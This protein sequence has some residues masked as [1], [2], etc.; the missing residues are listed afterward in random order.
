MFYDSRLL[1]IYSNYGKH[2]VHLFAPGHA[3]FGPLPGNEYGY[4]GGTSNAAPLVVGVA[5]LLKSYFP[6]L[7]MLQIKEI[8]LETVQRPDLKVI[9]PQFIEPGLR[10]LYG[11]R[12]LTQ[13]ELVPFQSLSIT[14]GIL[15]AEAAV[16]KALEITKQ[17][18]V[19]GF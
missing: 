9:R 7:S 15:D 17:K 14:G 1:P 5:A 8:I 12:L 13:G 11:L 18:S 3:S 19:K 16:R 6:Q 4:A 10:L 2:T